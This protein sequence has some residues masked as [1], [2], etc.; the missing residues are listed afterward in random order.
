MDRHRQE[1]LD[2]ACSEEVLL[3]IKNDHLLI[4]SFWNSC[5]YYIVYE[6]NKDAT[7]EDYFRGDSSTGSSITPEIEEVTS[8]TPQKGCKSDGEAELFFCVGTMYT[9]V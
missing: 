4:C 3:Y 8:L 9:T 5:I 1:W 6:Q 2:Y 7:C